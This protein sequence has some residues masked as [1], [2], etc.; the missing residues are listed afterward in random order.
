[1]CILSCNHDLSQDVDHVHPL[2]VPKNPTTYV[3][4]ISITMDK[5]CLFYKFV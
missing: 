3:D 1:M 5:F 4:L 2:R